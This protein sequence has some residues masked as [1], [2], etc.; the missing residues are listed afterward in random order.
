[1]QLSQDGPLLGEVGHAFR[2]SGL[3][4]APRS[5]GQLFGYERGPGGRSPALVR[6]L[7]RRLH[8]DSRFVTWQQV[9]ALASEVR[10]NVTRADVAPLKELYQPDPQASL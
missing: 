4:V 6:M 5:T 9:E 10:L 8:H 1:M 2:L 7:I 3:V